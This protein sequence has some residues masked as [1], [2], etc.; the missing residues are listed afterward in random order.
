M[1]LADALGGLLGGLLTGGNPASIA[2]GAVC[3]S[4]AVRFNPVIDYQNPPATSQTR[5]SVSQEN[6]SLDFLNKCAIAVST[7]KDNPKLLEAEMVDYSFA[8]IPAIY[9]D[10][11]IKNATIHNAALTVMQTGQL[12][13]TLSLT[14]QELDIIS[15]ESFKSNYDKLVVSILENKEFVSFELEGIEPIVFNLFSEV[16]GKVNDKDDIETIINGYANIIEQ[17][18]SLSNSSKD[19]MY[20]SLVIAAY[21]YNYWNS[22]NN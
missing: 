5:S 8:S 1:V 17:N 2:V 3:F 7:V 22:N 20:E 6:Q 14:E 4:G 18:S 11:A 12:L 21:S 9:S 15:N 19:Y 13:D 10:R 16:F